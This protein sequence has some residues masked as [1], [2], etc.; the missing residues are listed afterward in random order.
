[1]RTSFLSWLLSIPSV[2]ALSCRAVEER[3]LDCNNGA[4]K[5]I[6][7]VLSYNGPVAT[8]LCSDILKRGPG[9]TTTVV[10]VKTTTAFSGSTISTVRSGVTA[11]T[12]DSTLS[13]RTGE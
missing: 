11:T 5:I 10:S 6:T 1:M 4:I 9:P 13:L 8:R 7:S 3:A 12:I 2:S